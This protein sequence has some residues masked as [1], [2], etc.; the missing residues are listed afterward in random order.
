MSDRIEPDTISE[1]RRRPKARLPYALL[2]LAVLA[3]LVFAATAI[4]LRS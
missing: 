3:G 1:D 4:I 2:W